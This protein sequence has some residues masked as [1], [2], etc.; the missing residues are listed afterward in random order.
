M[1]KTYRYPVLLL[2][3]IFTWLFG[4]ALV[5]ED[6]GANALAA[7]RT[8]TRTPVRAFYEFTRSSSSRILPKNIIEEI[9]FFGG[10]G[11]VICMP[12]SKPVKPDV[13]GKPAD[14]ILMTQSV[15]TVCGWQKGEVLKGTIIYP[16]G[17]EKTKSIKVAENEGLY[18]GRLEFTPGISDPIGNYTFVMEG[19]LGVAR[20]TARFSK[21]TGPHLFL[22]DKKNIMFYGFSPHEKVNLF[23]YA[24]GGRFEGWQEYT[25]DPAGQLIVKVSV[26]PDGYFW[27]TGKTG[28]VQLPKAHGLTGATV[29]PVYQTTIK[30]DYCSGPVSRLT[31]MD[32]GRVAFTDGKDM[33]IR[34]APGLSASIISTVPEGTSFSVA[35]GPKCADGITWW[36]VNIHSGNITGWMAESDGKNYLIEDQ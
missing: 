24:P 22:L 25:M 12:G 21:P 32:S 1:M 27:A 7:T 34:S 13:V 26:N 14:G 31:I 18:Y 17:T 35:E 19:K 23:Y 2:I 15:M 20:Q 33:R 30:K 6:P 29:Y 11:G 5:S 9:F 36:K 10:G 4:S 8:P 16:N 3:M 28:E